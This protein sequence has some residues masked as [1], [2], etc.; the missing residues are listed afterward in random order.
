M[1]QTIK[2][3]TIMC[4]GNTELKLFNLK[5]AREEILYAMSIID[6]SMKGNDYA[7]VMS[8]LATALKDLDNEERY[9]T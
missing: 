8:A 6:T 2:G 5:H 1:Y 4:K 9:N 7:K 3:D